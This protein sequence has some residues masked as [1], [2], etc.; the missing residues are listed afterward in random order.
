M[1]TGGPPYS[2]ITKS[3]LRRPGE[4]AYSLGDDDAWVLDKFYGFADGTGPCD[5]HDASFQPRW[6]ADSVAVGGND[7]LYQNTGL[8]FMMGITDTRQRAVAHDWY[9]RAIAGGSP[10]VTWTLMPATG[11]TI[12]TSDP[13]RLQW[14]AFMKSLLQS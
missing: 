11:H 3:C 5:A 13:G 14:L 6:D 7:Y 4:S 1:P 10:M 2:A 9:N 8:Y 12:W